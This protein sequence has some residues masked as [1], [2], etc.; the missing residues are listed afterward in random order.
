MNT[1]KIVNNLGILYDMKQT[2]SQNVQQDPLAFFNDLITFCMGE[3]FRSI[4]QF[5]VRFF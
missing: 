1:L 5:I 3:G 4:F 2:Y